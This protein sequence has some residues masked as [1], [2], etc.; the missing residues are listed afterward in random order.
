MRWEILDV[1]RGSKGDKTEA[2]N[3]ARAEAKRLGINYLDGIKA[4]AVVRENALR[5]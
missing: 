2:E 1:L 5:R 4:G 3:Y